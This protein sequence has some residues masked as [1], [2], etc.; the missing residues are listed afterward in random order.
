M[1][2]IYSPA[3][4]FKRGNGMNSKGANKS[5]RASGVLMH[6]SSLFGDYSIGS[7][8]KEAKAFAD[9]LH[10]GGFSIWQVLPFCMA[11]ESN[12]PYKSYSAFGGNPLFIDL[13]TLHKKGL[14]TSDELAAARQRTP[15]LCEYKRLG[16]ERL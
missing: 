9:F 8:G 7:F 1:G 10:R 6:I 11:D 13:P 15:Y 5:G 12:S 2:R 16:E 3:A 14:I 4:G